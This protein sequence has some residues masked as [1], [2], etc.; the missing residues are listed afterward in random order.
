[1]AKS[2]TTVV[3]VGVKGGSSFLMEVY[4]TSPET[5]Y[6]F[7]VLVQHDSTPTTGSVWLLVFDLFKAAP[8]QPDVRLVH[9]KFMSGTPAEQQA[10]Q[11]MMSGV[12]PAQADK[13]ITNVYPATKAIVGTNPTPEQKQAIHD[14]MSSVVNVDV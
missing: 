3:P 10:L 5:G 7:E 4:V 14:A 2:S 8:G 12:Q 9:V 1:M 11:N 13:L 6:K